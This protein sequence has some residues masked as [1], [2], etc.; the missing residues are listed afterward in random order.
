MISSICIETLFTEH[1]FLKRIEETKRAGFDYI[2]FWSWED[3]NLHDIKS[4]C[5][6]SGVS[7]ASFSG[8]KDFSAVDF[9]HNEKYLDYIKN[10]A[11]KSKL[12]GLRESCSTLECFGRGRCCAL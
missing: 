7:I 8:D 5:R 12:L 3:K 6:D 9:T 10:S 11:E 4:A 2:E 1:P